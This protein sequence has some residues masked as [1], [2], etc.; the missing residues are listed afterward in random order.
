[1]SNTPKSQTPG[2]ETP[3]PS[4]SA[5]TKAVSTI[6]VV[7]AGALA[8][9]VNVAASR[10]YKRWDVSRAQ[11]YTLS[12]PTTVTLDSLEKEGRDVELFVFLGGGDPLLG[13]VKAILTNYQARAPQHLHIRYL[14]PDR[15]RVDFTRLQLE[16][17]VVAGKSEAGRV[18]TDA[19]I[20]ARSGKRIWY[21]KTDD[22]VVLEEGDD[23]KARPRVEQAVTGAIR[24]VLSTERMRL[25]FT[26]GHR[27][28]ALDDPGKDGLSALK[29]MLAKDN[30]APEAVDLK[31]PGATLAGC[32]LIAVIGPGEP[33]KEGEDKPILDAVTK[34]TPLLLVVPPVI[35]EDTHGLKAHGLSKVAALAGVTLDDAIA[36]EESPE[37]REPNGFGLILRARVHSHATTDEL[38]KFVE[39][40]GVEALVPLAFARPMVKVPTPGVQ[41]Q[42]LLV[43]DDKSF[44]L[45]DVTGFIQSKEEPKRSPSDRVGPLD[46]AVA[47]ERDKSIGGAKIVV[48]GSPSLLINATYLDPSP[49]TLI[50][51]AMGQTWLSWLTSRPAILDLPPKASTQIA[52]HMTED[53]IGAVFRYVVVY[54]P[55]SVVLIGGAVFL[56]RRQ[57]EGKRTRE[58]RKTGV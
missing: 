10:H 6:G 31:K 57:T 43:T 13:S 3:P 49:P 11:L 52:F 30:Y 39:S 18:M 37:L 40:R 44:A 41:P 21:V 1:M 8:L 2:K 56:R 50:D 4:L 32:A 36:V 34:G 45:R 46:L 54:M 33:F 16:L 24:A 29:N 51:R 38:K 9:L 42:E 22:M 55:I 26:T 15:D 53:Q 5:R 7:A 48:V 27:E 25:C 17:D 28:S 35:D 12:E 23:A 20:V 14:D 58:P 19:Q 47:V